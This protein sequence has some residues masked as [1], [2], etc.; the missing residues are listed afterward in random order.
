MALDDGRL[1]MHTSLSSV[2]LVL[3]QGTGGV[4]DA[5]VAERPSRVSGH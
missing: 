4:A 2:W 3:G 5:P 1:L